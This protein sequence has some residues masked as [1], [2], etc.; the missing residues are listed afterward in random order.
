MPEWSAAIRY[1]TYPPATNSSNRPGQHLPHHP[2]HLRPRV[3]PG[4]L[5]PPNPAGL[6][7]KA[8]ASGTYATGTGQPAA[9]GLVRNSPTDFSVSMRQREPPTYRPNGVSS[10]SVGPVERGRYHPGSGEPGSRTRWATRAQ[11]SSGNSSPRSPGP[12]LP[13]R[14]RAW[15]CGDADA[16]P[17]RL[18][19]PEPWCRRER[20]RRSPGLTEG[21]HPEGVVPGNPLA[22]GFPPVVR[23][24]FDR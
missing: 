21:R 9:A 3:D 13:R 12:P 19:R 4:H 6:S 24:V 14:P 5:S 20:A 2:V 1:Y 17:G 16:G 11:A 22:L 15:V 10:E 8:P 18:Q 23:W 7:R